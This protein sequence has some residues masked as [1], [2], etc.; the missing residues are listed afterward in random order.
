MP[1]S[2]LEDFILEQLI[3]ILQL[4][5]ECSK[6]TK[7][8]RKN[9]KKMLSDHVIQIPDQLAFSPQKRKNPNKN[10][11]TK[12]NRRKNSFFFILPAIVRGHPKFHFPMTQSPF[13]CSNKF[14]LRVP[15]DCLPTASISFRQAPGNI[16]ISY[17]RCNICFISY[18]TPQICI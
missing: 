13:I 11:K 18:N 5:E 10:V 14:C 12:K 2:A 1:A 9:N 4:L 7:N 16:T 8:P 6:K 3:I 17:H 15:V